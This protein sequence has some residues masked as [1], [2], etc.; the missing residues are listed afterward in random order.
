MTDGNK[1]EETGKRTDGQTNKPTEEGMRAYKREIPRATDQ[2]AVTP[3]DR[4][5]DESIEMGDTGCFTLTDTRKNDII[6]KLL[7]F[8][9]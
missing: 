9:T 7:V 2:L 6:R 5:K 4:R 8:I 1:Q 3:T